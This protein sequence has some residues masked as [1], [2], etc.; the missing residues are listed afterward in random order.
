MLVWDVHCTEC[1]APFQISD[2]EAHYLTVNDMP[3]ICNDCL[4]DDD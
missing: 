4:G 3:A 2:D 1:H